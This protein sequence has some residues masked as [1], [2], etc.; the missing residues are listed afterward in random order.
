[1][2][3][4]GLAGLSLLLGLMSAAAAGG[5]DLPRGQIVPDV[6]CLA[7]ASQ[8]YAL[9]LPSTYSPDKAWP[10][11]MGFHPGARGIAIVEKYRAAAEK[12]GYIVAASNN[13]RNGPWDV[14][15]RAVVAMTRD[16]AARFT[17][18][19]KRLYATGHSG[20]AR[21][22]MQI[23]LT[24]P[25]AGIIASS[26]G[27]PDSVPRSKLKFVVFGTAGDTDFNYIELK[28]LDNA[29]KTPHRVVIFDGGHT[30]PPDDLAL[31]AVEWL[32]LQAIKSGIR[33]RDEDLVLGLWHKRLSA[34]LKPEDPVK[35]VPLLQ[36]VV[37][38]FKG[39]HDTKNEEDAVKLL[40]KDT[41]TKRALDH[42]RNVDRAE[43]QALDDV[44][45]WEAGLR[46]ATSRS[47]SLFSLRQ[48]LQNL[49]KKAGAA[50]DSAERDSARRLLRI[51]SMN[52]A[53]RTSDKDYLALLEKYKLF[54]TGR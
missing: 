45:V 19:Q 10:L 42:K 27:Y 34:A 50:A 20:G 52:A 37:E 36:A 23:A 16:L 47:E 40:L 8:S 9:Y 1:M 17:T 38:D 35:T 43:I 21:V 29:L 31:E 33:A 28:L 13:S 15:E 18:D 22:A 25:L 4:R 32:E 12:Y 2:A 49:Q 41:D 7:D 39:L 48:L 26:A 3:A 6:K 24:N 54:T 44:R 30:L 51:L 53:E 11:L 5:Q 14:S 46:D